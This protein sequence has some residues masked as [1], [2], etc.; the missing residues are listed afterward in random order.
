MP[1]VRDRPPPLPSKDDDSPP[2]SPSSD[3]STETARP[4]T[5]PP[6]MSA[7]S[8]QRQF[9]DMRNLIGT[10]IGRTEDL[11]QKVAA[12]RAVDERMGRLEAMLSRALS[13]L[14]DSLVD[15]M[16]FSRRRPKSEHKAS[17]VHSKAP[18]AKSTQD[19]SYLSRGIDGAYPD[20]SIQKA[21]APPNSIYDH[22]SQTWSPIPDSLLEPIRRGP[23]FDPEFELANLPPN[24]PPEL[25]ES[26]PIAVPDFIRNRARAQGPAPAQ[27]PAQPRQE[28]VYS[29][30][31]YQ[32][33]EYEPTPVQTPAP[34]PPPKS[35]SLE[36]TPREEPM[37]DLRDQRPDIMPQDQGIPDDQQTQW[38][39]DDV[40]HDP[41]RRLPPPQPVDLP[42]P[43]RSPGQLASGPQM[44]QPYGPS[45]PPG[46]GPGMM[47]GMGMP[48]MMPPG[49][50]QMPRPTMPRIAGVRD[51]ISTT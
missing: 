22:D 18:T 13:H 36:S 38:S 41:S 51:P 2:P 15:D 20:E 7:D 9:D 39:M 16:D 37:Q 47:P 5:P 12:P 3:A 42:T 49:A 30:G 46:G 10:L 26:K 31:E 25:Y 27:T 21:P 32:Q 24:T 40:A 8:V 44:P 43:V 48:P 1:G 45:V 14:D 23:D 34:L 19:G 28:D 17:S 6:Y 35:P 33:T 29:Q 4:V 11:A 50:G